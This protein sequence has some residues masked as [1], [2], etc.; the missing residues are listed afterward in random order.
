MIIINIEIIIDIKIIIIIDNKMVIDNE[1]IMDN[2][3]FNLFINLKYFVKEYIS[4]FFF[5]LSFSIKINDIVYFKIIIS[6]C[7]SYYIINKYI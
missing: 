4:F 5:L 2:N 3:I 6:I 1:I 7:K